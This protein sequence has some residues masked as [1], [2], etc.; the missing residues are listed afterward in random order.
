VAIRRGAETKGGILMATQTTAYSGGC[1]CGNLAIRF[2]TA[3]PLEALP[4]RACACSFCTRHGTRCTSDPA[5]QV[6]IAVHDPERLERYRFGL[7][8]T[9]YLVC[10]TCGVYA[11]AVLDGDA[12]AVAIV[13]INSLAEADHGWQAAKVVTYDGETEPERRAR[14]L[15]TWTPAVEIVAQD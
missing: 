12:G 8:T 5:G 6:E 2:E 14:R 1:H 10:K 13:N 3:L 11:A 7:G 9:D 15:D 4:V